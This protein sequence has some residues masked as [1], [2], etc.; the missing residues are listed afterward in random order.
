MTNSQ[1]KLGKRHPVLG[2]IADDVTG[3]TDLSINLVQGGLRVVQMLGVPD[4]Q[5]LSEVENVDAIVIA[6]KTRSV[7]RNDAITESLNALR[8]LI[9]HGVPRYYFK[10]CSTFDSTRD[11]NIGPVAEALMHELDVRQT[12]FCP[13]FPR[14]GR[15]VYRG[16]LFVGDQLLNESGMQ[17]HPLNPMT[18]ANLVRVL[19]QQAT[20][21]VG[22]LSYETIHAG[23]S[24]CRSRLAELLDQGVSLVITDSCDNE[25]LTTLAESVASMP[26]LTGGSGLARYLPQAYRAAGI[27]ESAEFVPDLPRIAGRSLILAGS[28]STA[29][30]AQVKWMQGKCPTW[31]V[32]VAALMTDSQAEFSKLKAWALETK[33]DETLLVSSSAAPKQVAELQSNFGAHAVASAI[34]RFLAAV[35]KTLVEELD[36]RRLVLAG[37]ETSGAIVR[38]WYSL[39]ANRSGN[40]HRSALDGDH[41]TR[42]AIGTGPKIRQF[43]RGRFFC[44][45]LGDVAM[46]EQEL[47]ERISAYGKSLFERGLTAGSSGNISVRL[48]DGMLITP[49][50]ASL[51]RLDPDRITKLNLSG[52]L[53][54]GDQPSKEAFLHHSLYRSRPQEQAI[55]HLHST[56]SVAVSCLADIDPSNALPPITAYYVMRVGTLPLVP[57][58]A[59]G[60]EQLALAVEQAAKLSRA[61]LLSNHGPVVAGKSLDAAVNSVEE[62]E[63]TAKLFLLLRRENTQYLADTQVAELLK[64]FPS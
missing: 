63:E 62:L 29:T 13:A 55:V 28:C 19:S 50:N 35:A 34:E 56:Y 9:C 3:A 20:G 59:P 25:Q 61:V 48:H 23:S 6:L 42:A 17:A 44:N 33:A 38:T 32:D 26:L 5:Q 10:Y 8:A 27:V 1:V 47:R 41:W 18:D 12:I 40:L 4:A 45:G 54:A 16:H 60:D 22:L 2:C 31:S 37:G 11:G 52:E 64:R 30:N 15:T 46:S 24:A 57:Y 7:P 51:G 49:T 58:Y 36:V 43:W 53:V 14:A 39:A 21:S